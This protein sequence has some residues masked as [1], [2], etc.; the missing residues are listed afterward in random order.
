MLALPQAKDSAIRSK[1]AVH[2]GAERK[3][4]V[5]PRPG[6]FA[7]LPWGGPSGPGGPNRTGFPEP[8]LSS[9]TLGME[10]SGAV[11]EPGCGGVAGGLGG[12][13]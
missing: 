3:R 11:S 4:Q 10:V 7:G 6:W 2:A 9:T 13:I 5:W 1:L 8:S 12:C